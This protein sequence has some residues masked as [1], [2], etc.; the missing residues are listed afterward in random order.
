MSSLWDQ[1]CRNQCQNSPAIYSGA[2]DQNKCRRVWRQLAG[3]KKTFKM[4]TEKKHEEPSYTTAPALESA[5]FAW[6]KRT[7]VLSW[8]IALGILDQATC[9]DIHSTSFSEMRK[10]AEP[11]SPSRKPCCKST[12]Y[13][14]YF[15]TPEASS[16]VF[17]QAVKSH[18]PI[19]SLLQSSQT[20]TLCLVP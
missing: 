20:V 13:T 17:Q 4:W 2:E 11:F 8:P 18:V 14:N 9:L 3:N 6:R 15:S 16:T 7:H 19:Q 5:Q 12:A 10:M 1:E